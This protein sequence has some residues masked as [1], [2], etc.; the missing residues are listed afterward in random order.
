MSDWESTYDG[1]GAALGG[2]DLEMPNA[3]CMTPKTLKAALEIGILTEA[4]ID[5]KIRRLLSLAERFHWFERAQQDESIPL[6]DSS[7]SACALEMA[8]EGCVLLKN[9]KAFLPVEAGQ[10]SKVTVI[11]YQGHPAVIC[12]GGSAYAKPFHETS[13]Q[14]GLRA[15]LPEN[16]ELR[17]APG[18]TPEKLGTVGQRRIFTQKN[19]EPGVVA[20]YWANPRLEGVPSQTQIQDDMYVMWGGGRP[21]RGWDHRAFATRWTGYFTAED[22]GT[23]TLHINTSGKITITLNGDVVAFREA[24]QEIGRYFE[25][26]IQL[27][28]GRRYC[29]RVDC[30]IPDWIYNMLQIGI[31]SEAEWERWREEAVREAEGAD[32]IVFCAGYSSN[33]ESEGYDRGF[34]LPAGQA[35]LIERLAAINPNVAVLLFSGGGVDCLPWLESVPALLQVWYPGQEGGQA[36]A[37]ILTGRVNPSGKLPMTFDRRLEDRSSHKSYHDED[38]DGRVRITDGVFTGYRHNDQAGVEPLFAFGHGLSYTTFVLGDPQLSSSEIG[39]GDTLK[40]RVPVTN[41]GPLAG[42]EVVQVYVGEAR[43]TLPRPKRELKAFSKVFLKPGE[44]QAVTLELGEKSWRYWCPERRTWIQ[45]PGEFHLC[46]GTSSGH[47]PH[48]LTAHLLAE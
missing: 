6:D 19:G 41:T 45:N 22:G 5:E 34:A 16:C 48:R 13:V 24:T 15:L 18:Y 17:F 20:E 9:E 4:M 10:L 38:G 2:L 1:I 28:A 12:G 33:S 23:H 39:P 43:P 30:E 44:S 7:S 21:V 42:A 40:I 32:L 26:T 46:I 31:S 29:L 37:E 11:G 25:T 36:I 8:R 35:E 3:K 47:L 27:E 14:D